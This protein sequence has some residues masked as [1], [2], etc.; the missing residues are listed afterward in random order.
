MADDIKK[1]G[2]DEIKRRRERIVEQRSGVEVG[3][4]VH[5]ELVYI[6][7]Q[8]LAAIEIQTAET[9]AA[10]RDEA[11]R[12]PDLIAETKR[13][14]S[15]E[16]GDRAAV[17]AFVDPLYSRFKLLKVVTESPETWRAYLVENPKELEHSGG[18]LADFA[19]PLTLCAFCVQATWISPGG[20][21][22]HCGKLHEPVPDP[23]RFCTS[24]VDTVEEP[25]IVAVSKLFSDN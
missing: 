9:L 12:L 20:R 4:Y 13:R 17:N 23:V 6:Y 22:P 16:T 8:R 19:P 15:A 5:D 18:V 14:L 10:A 3:D 25:D 1:L 24:F 21:P 2:K 11:V 7:G